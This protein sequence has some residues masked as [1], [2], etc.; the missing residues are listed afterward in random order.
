M[1]SGSTSVVSPSHNVTL[2]GS[3][4]LHSHLS[5][6]SIGGPQSIE[7]HGDAQMDEPQ[8]LTPAQACKIRNRTSDYS[9]FQLFE[10]FFYL[11]F[12]STFLTLGLAS[13]THTTHVNGKQ[14]FCS[15]PANS[16]HSDWAR[17]SGS[18]SGTFAIFQEL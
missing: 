18:S 6:H 11:Y 5:H 17:S 9:H 1:S 13:Y 16:C 12:N 14:P 4:H 8:D 7:G 2:M 15:R 3:H 10:T